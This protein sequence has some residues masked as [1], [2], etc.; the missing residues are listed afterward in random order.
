MNELIIHRRRA[1]AA[2]AITALIVTMTS[3]A[4][5]S[6]L[7]G[8][9]P[10]RTESLGACVR[11]ETLFTNDV[12]EEND[13]VDEWSAT[14]HA[15]VRTIVDE[16]VEFLQSNGACLSEDD[17]APPE[18]ELKKLIEKLP[19]WKDKED[20]SQEDMPSI[21]TDYLME[22]E[23][24]LQERAIT[25]EVAV[26]DDFVSENSNS[27]D[28]SSSAGAKTLSLDDYDDAV[29]TQG[30]HIADEKEIS[31]DALK[32]TLVYL[33]GHSRVW[34]LQHSLQCLEGSMIDIRN[35]LVL[36]GNASTCMPMKLWDT[37]TFIRAL[38]T[39]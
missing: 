10:V 30:K 3:W 34:R 15:Q 33:S 38:K 28:S 9:I 18:P 4:S 16:H 19:S 13:I 36:A 29:S 39:Q 25:L 7:G 37:Q 2:G 27:A 22:Y 17:R 20:V 32:R 1:I 24:A 35:A 31:R 26:F 23:C 11:N 21:L 6:M 8:L 14:Y 12:G 5:G